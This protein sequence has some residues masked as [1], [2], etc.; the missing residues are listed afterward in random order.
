M[1]TN[2]KNRIISTKEKPEDKTLD[3]T[4]IFKHMKKRLIFNKNM[5]WISKTLDKFSGF[6]ILKIVNPTVFSAARLGRQFLFIQ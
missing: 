1:P 5:L 2:K 3:L 6:A 4:L